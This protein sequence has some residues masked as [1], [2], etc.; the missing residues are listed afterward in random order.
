MGHYKKHSKIR[1]NDIGDE[2]EY[3]SDGETTYYPEKRLGTG[4][5]AHAR[6]FKSRSNKPQLRK[7]VVVLK[8]VKEKEDLEEAT[9][10]HTF[11][12]TLYTN[13]QS[14]LFNT[15]DGYRLVL[16]YIPY[17]SY[18]KLAID[19]PK[20]QRILFYSAVEAL[21]DCHQKGMIVVDLK[22]DNIYYDSVYQKSYLIDGGLST[23]INTPIDRLV[24][25]KANQTTV[26][27]LQTKYEHIPPE[28]WSVAPNSS[29]ATVEMDIYSLGVLMIDVLND[30]DPALKP[31]IDACLDKNP[32][33]RPTLKQ[34]DISLKSLNQDYLHQTSSHDDL[35]TLTISEHKEVRNENSF[36]DDHSLNPQPAY[37]HT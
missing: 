8:S 30:I 17:V 34:L 1:S 18:E 5:Y 15:K 4:T 22:A 33:N 19:N 16:P 29:L 10:K 27:K 14:H 25:Q 32:K 35:G 37:R 11:F 2:S 36:L 23:H 13:N 26:E 7:E 9:N 24:F 21:N 20:F 12:H 28:C 6:L 31:L 3:E